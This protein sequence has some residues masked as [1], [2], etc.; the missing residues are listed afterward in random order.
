[1]H[2]S[3]I[4]PQQLLLCEKRVR[5]RGRKEVRNNYPDQT[6]RTEND[7][8]RELQHEA[9][10]LRGRQRGRRHGNKN[11]SAPSPTGG[12]NFLHEFPPVFTIV[13]TR[14]G[15]AEIC[16][17]SRTRDPRF[18]EQASH[19]QC[20]KKQSMRSKSD[21]VCAAAAHQNSLDRNRRIEFR[22]D[23]SCQS[24]TAIVRFFCVRS[25]HTLHSWSNFMIVIN[26]AR[27]IFY[28]S[29]RQRTRSE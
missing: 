8:S 14:P 24:S 3:I 29:L 7:V 11:D 13:S 21:R 17:D 19:R 23:I 26:V 15:W 27:D 1:M 28:H 20:G 12:L 18:G 6:W 10:A 9:R 2:I 4:F 16:A 5:S 22:R 25:A